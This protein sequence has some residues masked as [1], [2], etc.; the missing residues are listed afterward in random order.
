MII[1]YW[2][3]LN[4]QEEDEIRAYSAKIGWGFNETS[5]RELFKRYMEGDLKEK[6]KVCYLLEDCNYHTL[7]G[8]LAEGKVA[9][10]K[11]WIDD[12][13]PIEEPDT[14]SKDVVA[15]VMEVSNGKFLV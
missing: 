2:K 9:E 1:E 11:N 4:G 13:F 5:I 10:A 8:F 3:M 12:E 7:C 14:I 6:A 15:W